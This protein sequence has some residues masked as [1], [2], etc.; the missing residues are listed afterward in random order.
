MNAVL[1]LKSEI[2]EITGHAPETCPWRVFYDPI[3]ARVV[4]IA[5]LAE[6]GLGAPALGDDPPAILLDGLR[7][8][9]TSRNATRAYDWD[10]DPHN[11]KNARRR[12]ASR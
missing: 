3:V 10:R 6:E 1:G 4:G 8:Y 5:T 7:V 9:F 11:P 12:S 2:R